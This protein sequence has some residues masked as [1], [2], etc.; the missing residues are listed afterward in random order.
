[1]I[2]ENATGL[3]VHKP[4]TWEVPTSVERLAITLSGTSE[5]KD[6][7]INK[8]CLQ[9]SDSTLWRLSSHNPIT[10]IQIAGSSGGVSHNSTSGI[11][12]GSTGEYCHLTSAQRDTA[13]R[14]ANTTQSGLLTSTDWEYF[15][16]KAKRFIKCFF[17]SKWYSHFDRLEYVQRKA[18]CSNESNNRNW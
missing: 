10:W 2:H 3:S 13:T 1:M 14:N 7:F 6:K 16:R 18:K 17:N 12:G 11:Q 9:T 8:V 5:E 15:Q 4:W